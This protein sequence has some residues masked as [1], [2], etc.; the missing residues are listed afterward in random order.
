M[1]W[2]V[3]GKWIAGGFSLTLLIVGIVNIA[4]YRNLQA[5]MTSYSR[6]QKTYE[7]LS[8]LK[9]F[10]A[11]MTVAESGRRGYIVAGSQQ[12]LERHETGVSNM[13]FELERL[14]EQLKENSFEQQKL[15]EISSLAY[16]RLALFRRSIILYQIDP[17]ETL[18][19]TKITEKSVKVRNKIHQLLAEIKTE[20]DKNL[21]LWLK[22]SQTGFNY[23]ILLEILSSVLGF[24]ILSAVYLI[25]S[26]QYIRRRQLES[27]EHNL[28]QE[29]ELSELKLRLFSMISHEFRTP[30]SVIIASSQLLQ[31]N[32]QNSADVS[33]FKSLV[34]IQ[35]SAKLMNQ[36]LTDILTL[37]RAEIGKLEYKS[38]SLDV[39][40]F[41]LNL[42]EDLNFLISQKYAFKFTSKGCCS[43]VFADEKLLYSMLS[44]LILNS[45]KYSPNGGN[46]YLIVSCESD[47]I[48]FQVKDEGIGIPQADLER[49]YEPFYRSQNVDNI[50]G[51]G[52]GLAVVQKC[53]E[54]HQ[55]EI[56][57]ES[58]VGV[59]T[60]FTIKIPRNR[61]QGAGS[62]EQGRGGD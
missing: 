16:Q 42:V 34:R 48:L 28:T 1:K 40:V 11:N 12:E 9:D 60:T 51:S 25:L 3:E 45:I 6:V 54:L 26:R 43:R 35:S 44:N 17:S 46:I 50:V 15:E 24:T 62:R 14:R 27:L 7:I 36:L 52:L 33:K 58:Q 5:L 56:I 59:G 10:Y 61:E 32:L 31:E 13:R 29:K 23:R 49:I 4:S 22:R 2:S 41:C 39:E 37:T 38:E 47:K 19:Q 18:V 21:Q 57:V 20:E 55:G 30:L 53:L 8:N